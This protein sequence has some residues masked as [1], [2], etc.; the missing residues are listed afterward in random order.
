M[1][2]ILFSNVFAISNDLSKV[3]IPCLG[4]SADSTNYKKNFEQKCRSEMIETEKKL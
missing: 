1:T 4:S 3:S 2:F